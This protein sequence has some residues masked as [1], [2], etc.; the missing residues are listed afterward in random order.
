MNE[1]DLFGAGSLGLL[2]SVDVFAVWETRNNPAIMRHLKSHVLFCTQPA[3]GERN[4][5]GTGGVIGISKAVAGSV[6]FV[7]WRDSLPLGWVKVGSVFIGF[8]YLRPSLLDTVHVAADTVVQLQA[9]IAL[10][11]RLGQ[12]VL[13]GDFNAT[14]GAEQDA[15]PLPR[16]ALDAACPAGSCLMDMARRCGLAV[17]TGRLDGHEHTWQQGSRRSRIDHAF[18][19]TDVWEWVTECAP[20]PAFWGSDHRP[21]RLQL[22]HAD[23][24][25]CRTPPS[26][27]FLHWRYDAQQRY[28]AALAQQVHLW[29]QLQAAVA[30]GL[31]GL[32]SAL[33][34]SLIWAAAAAAGMVV[35]P[36]AARGAAA[37]TVLSLS[38]DGE[39]ARA[40][41]RS[42]TALGLP[43][44]PDVRRRWRAAVRDARCRRA[45]RMHARLS[46]CIWE[47]PRLFWKHFKKPVLPPSAVLHTDAWRAHYAAM[48]AGSVPPVQDVPAAVAPLPARPELLGLMRAVSP[49]EVVA[50]FCKLGTAKACGVDKLPA[51]FVTKAV[52]RLPDGS[53]VYHF[54]EVL[55][56]LFTHVMQ[57]CSV[58]WEWKVKC[59]HPVHKHGA[60]TDPANYRPLAVSTALYRLL[61]GI[62]AARVAPFTAPGPTSL[63]APM[64]FAF[65]RCMGVEHA[66][67]PVLTARDIALSRREPFALLKLDIRKAYDTV[68]RL[69]LWLAMQRSGL[70]AA[71][72]AL[73]QELYRDAR[74]VVAVNG[75]CSAPFV[76]TVGLLQ[77]CPLS[78]FLYSIFLREPLL[79]LN[80]LCAHLGF[81][82]GA[83]PCC[84]ANFADDI[85]AMLASVAFVA[86]FLAAAERVLGGWCQSLNRGK[87]KLLV[88]T[89]ARVA[90]PAVPGD[91]GVEVVSSLKVLGLTYDQG[92]AISGNVAVR[93][94]KGKSKVALAMAR[95][96][97]VGCHSDMHMCLLL[98]NVDVRQ[99]LLFGAPLWGH[100]RLHPDPIQHPLQPVYS[101]LMRQAFGLPCSTAHWIV[102]FMAGQL[103]IQHWVIRDFY[104][105]W[106]R[107]ISV[108]D[109]SPLLKACMFV[110]GA[111]AV[112]G[113]DCWLHQWVTALQRVVPPAAPDAPSI[114]SELTSGQ[115]VVIAGERGVMHRCILHYDRLLASCGDPLS[116][117]CAHR[118]IAL[119]YVCM[120]VCGWGKRPW[121]HWCEVPPHVMRT[122]L[123]FVACLADAVPAQALVRPGVRFHDRL[124]TKCVMGVVANEEHVVLVCPATSR[125]RRAF[126]ASLV[127][128]RDVSL[129]ALLL[130]N[131]HRECVFFVHAALRAYST[132]PRLQ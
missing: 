126:H 83:V 96:R 107:L 44:P 75:V 67:L 4:V 129:R 110:Q 112:A 36:A 60:V 1:A 66:H 26:P 34:M 97:E 37:Y 61:S 127:W 41:L 47:K 98:L 89:P 51:E 39:A 63:L 70:P 72:I 130:A 27:P 3:P 78:P 123:Y 120:R 43:V 2:S 122:W 29:Q 121:W 118:R 30:A 7:E 58:P 64:Q 42:F 132:A 9:A 24:P 79:E 31:A 56:D 65:R 16:L 128:P 20:L 103:P 40:E 87:S 77:G 6:Q 84:L 54:A 45:Q 124:C 93:A 117:E 90:V 15:C 59:V 115:P 50:V 125:V 111:L 114:L 18:V 101:M 32:A 85:T 119:H 131:R 10:K 22:R 106:N 57:S 38:P 55:A 28:V 17:T 73:V 71:F 68:V 53:V 12:V 82:V 14:L 49:V 88:V 13:M 86:T 95:L 25:A 23:C 102:S 48:F 35:D 109:T 113:K 8:V 105:F 104:R 76:S 69:L 21:L 52:S 94:S 91:L 92:G 33:L 100:S 62:V 108:A 81:L 99:T 116:R 19:Q 74:Y 11:Q 5:A 80:N 46:Q